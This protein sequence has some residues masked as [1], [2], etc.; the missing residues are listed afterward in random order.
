MGFVENLFWC[1]CAGGL[2]PRTPAQDWQGYD[3]LPPL[4]IRFAL[5]GSNRNRGSGGETPG[6]QYGEG[7]G[8]RVYSHGK[9]RDINLNMRITMK[10]IPGK[11]CEDMISPIPHPRDARERDIV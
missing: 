8:V 6:R 3:N 9:E 5:P 10:M 2:R 7:G 11:L 4:N 1:A